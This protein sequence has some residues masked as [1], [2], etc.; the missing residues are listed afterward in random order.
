VRFETA[1]QFLLPFLRPARRKAG[2]G[3]ERLLVAA[4]DA[5]VAVTVVRHPRA[6]NY[7]L[8]I[9]ESSRQ[10]V[11]TMPRRGSLRE[12]RA[13][14]ERNAAWI[15]ARL[16]RLPAPVPFIPGFS[17]P[18]RGIPHVIEHRPKARGTVWTEEHDGQA[19][20]CVTGPPEHLRR[21]LMDFLKR[22]AR[23][24]LATASRH[25]SAILE[26]KI[27]RIGVR[28]TGSRWGSCSFEGTLSFSWRL[29]LAPP[30][31][32]DYLTAHEVAHRVELNH[33]RRF[34]R[35]VERLVPEWRRAEAW[36]KAH[37]NGLHRF[38]A[39]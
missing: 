4:A 20:L 36:L 30:Y 18:L 15:A 27:G 39:G 34:W 12:A 2:P 11:L 5:A 21:R 25:Y 31:V 8:R 38:G 3:P 19:I 17:I 33:S 26:V 1:A 6:R 28:D 10:A 13:F 29:V 14:A 23:R 37:G 16:S 24:D 9:K 32:L 7:N 35:V 22:E